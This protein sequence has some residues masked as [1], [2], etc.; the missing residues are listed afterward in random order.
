MYVKHTL[1]GYALFVVIGIWVH[2]ILLLS[3]LCA[4]TCTCVGTTRPL[5]L[6]LRHSRTIMGVL[7]P[8]TVCL[9][10]SIRAFV[11]VIYTLL[12]L[13]LCI[14]LLSCVPYPLQLIPCTVKQYRESSVSIHFRRLPQA[15][16]ALWGAQQIHMSPAIVHLSICKER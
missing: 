12:P 5:S 16:T 4:S 11:W 14:V 1:I 7:R 8:L 3:V 9:R 15:G 6:H 2:Y 13:A 10:S